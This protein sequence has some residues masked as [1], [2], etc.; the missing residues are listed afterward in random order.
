MFRSEK[1]YLIMLSPAERKLIRYCLI[2]LKNKLL[3]AHFNTDD[4]D[5]LIRRISEE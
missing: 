3:S 1:K 4:I 5:A 2:E